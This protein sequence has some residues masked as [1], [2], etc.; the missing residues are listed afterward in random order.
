M[1][2]HINNNDVSTEAGATSPAS[3]LQNPAQLSKDEQK[4]LPE[5]QP[6]Q[7]YLVA[8]YTDDLFVAHLK[9]IDTDTALRDGFVHELKKLFSQLNRGVFILVA[10][11]AAVDVILLIR[12]FA[13][14]E[15][16]I[17]SEKV[18]LALIAGTVA[19]AGA[20]IIGI[21]GYLF[22]KSKA[23]NLP[24]GSKG[25][26][27]QQSIQKDSTAS[28]EVQAS[29]AGDALRTKDS[30]VEGVQSMLEKIKGPLWMV[31]LLILL[32]LFVWALL[33]LEPTKRESKE[34]LSLNNSFLMTPF[35]PVPN[36]FFKAPVAP[37]INLSVIQSVESCSAISAP[38]QARPYHRTVP[39]ATAKQSVECKSEAK[40]SVADKPLTMSQSPD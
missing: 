26:M 31:V 27:A 12:G 38:L 15:T 33:F 5:G 16:R 13:G 24:L 8:N 10:G 14:P 20:A 2:V 34:P 7:F 22:P 25:G 19:Q 1:S 9:S 36:D 29:V 23:A 11:L 4:P 17:V 32:A 28:N 37:Q 21:I 6:E 35:N 18:V 39:T 40:P 3:S 30:K